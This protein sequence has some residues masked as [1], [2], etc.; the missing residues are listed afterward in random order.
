MVTVFKRHRTQAQQT[1]SGPGRGAATKQADETLLPSGAVTVTAAMR[2]RDAAA[3]PAVAPLLP[4]DQAGRGAAAQPA[5][6]SYAVLP[7][8]MIDLDQTGHCQT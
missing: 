3:K 2:A 7:S 8:T 4:H 1:E 5:K 6:A